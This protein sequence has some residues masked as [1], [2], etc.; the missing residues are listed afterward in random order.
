[1]RQII[2]LTRGSRNLYLGDFI[3]P[4]ERAAFPDDPLLAMKNKSMETDF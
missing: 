4:L 3:F 2:S 1:M